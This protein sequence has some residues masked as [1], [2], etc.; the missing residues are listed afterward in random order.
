MPRPLVEDAG[1]TWHAAIL[2]D[3]LHASFDEIKVGDLL[4]SEPLAGQSM[5][6]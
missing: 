1:A 4:S 5:A 6:E 3:P 2:D